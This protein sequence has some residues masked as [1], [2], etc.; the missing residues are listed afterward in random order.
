MGHSITDV[1]SLGAGIGI[2]CAAKN[3]DK[4]AQIVIN[5]PT[6][7][8]RPLMETFSE[9]KGYPVDMFINSEEALEMV[10]KDTLVMVVD[11]NRPSYTECPELL[12]KTGKIVVFDHHR[13]SSEIIENPILSYIER[14]H[15]VRVRW[16][17]RYCST[18]TTESRSMRQRP[19][20][21]TQEFSS[22]PTTL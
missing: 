10:S 2:Y 18:S 1:D 22:T 16:S 13:Q 7:S 19:T 21:S 12:R 3:L 9:A 8:V 14:M 20:A 6:S 4:K 15:R 5:D 11:T 17:Q